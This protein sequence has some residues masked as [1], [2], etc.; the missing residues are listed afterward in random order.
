MLSRIKT[1]RGKKRQNHL[2]SVRDSTLKVLKPVFENGRVLAI[3]YKMA[4][5]N[6]DL[7]LGKAGLMWLLRTFPAFVL[8]YGW[9]CR[10][11]RGYLFFCLFNFFIRKFQTSRIKEFLFYPKYVNSKLLSQINCIITFIYSKQKYLA[12]R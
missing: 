4:K 1:K 11:K 8:V 3:C 10:N 7:E 12:K 6:D 9:V 2:Y 5:T